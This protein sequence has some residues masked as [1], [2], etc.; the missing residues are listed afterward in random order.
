MTIIPTNQLISDFYTY[1]A[2]RKSESTAKTY[3][4]VLEKLKEYLDRHNLLLNRDSVDTYLH[5]K[6]PSTAYT[7]YYALRFFAKYIKHPELVDDIQLKRFRRKEAEFITPDEVKK[8]ISSCLFPEHKAIIMFTYACA[9]RL[10]EVCAIRVEDIDMENGFLRIQTEKYTTGSLEYD[11]I[12]IDQDVLTKIARFIRNQRLRKGDKLFR[13][14]YTSIQGMLRRLSVY[15]A[16]KKISPHTL[17]HS[18]ATALA[19]GGT[20][21]PYLQKFLRHKSIASTMEYVHVIPTDLKDTIK[22]AF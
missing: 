14:K 17:R 15:V 11:Y 2:Q 5:T 7:Y 1:T 13:M 18:R 21:I 19:K 8:L 20:E 6:N 4:F 22:P 16:P 12:P 10:G 9:L 3:T